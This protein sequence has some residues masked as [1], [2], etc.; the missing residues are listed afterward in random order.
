MSRRPTS[1]G[2]T[3]ARCPNRAAR[4]VPG[5]PRDGAPGAPNDLPLFVYRLSLVSATQLVPSQTLC[6]VRTSVDKPD[7]AVLE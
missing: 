1:N 2:S 3:I 4:Q 6:L 7:A 5:G